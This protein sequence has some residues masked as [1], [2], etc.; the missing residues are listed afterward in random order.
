MNVPKELNMSEYI[1]T[2]RECAL[3]ELRP[4]LA[5]AI[6]AQIAQYELD[7]LESAALMCIESTATRKK[8]GLFG[9]GEVI[10]TGVLLTPKWLVWAAGK[11]G[12]KPAA[13]SARLQ[14][15][16]VKEYEKTAMYAIAPDEGINI[17]GRYTDVTQ[18]G[19]S[20]IGLGPEPAAQKFRQ[21]LQEAVQK[22]SA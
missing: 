7:T 9:G 4:E 15:I 3:D 5:A 6:R 19:M 1:R 14:D 11:Q 13:L 2:T 22:V 21:V 17:T 16:I 18:Q 10:H 20:F 8:K 12:E